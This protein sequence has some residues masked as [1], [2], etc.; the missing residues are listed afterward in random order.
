MTVAAA[1]VDGAPEAKNSF[2]YVI[3]HD[4]SNV[5]KIGKA[6]DPVFRLGTIQRMS[7]VK[8]E[9]RARFDGGYRLETALHRKFKHLRIHGEWF[10]FGG[11]DPL[12]EVKRAVDDIQAEWDVESYETFE[13]EFE[14][15]SRADVFLIEGRLRVM[16]D[17]NDGGWRCVGRSNT[18]G[19]RRHFSKG[20]CLN[21]FDVRHGD[22]VAAALWVIPGL[23]IV[24]GWDLDAG[25]EKI[26]ERALGQLCLRHFETPVECAEPWAIRLPSWEIFDPRRHAH[27]IRRFGR[28]AGPAVA[29][30]FKSLEG[31]VYQYVLG[32]L[33]R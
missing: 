6:D 12:A 31:E 25:D 32:N 24:D 13:A 30:G 19:E 8:L 21:D 16:P 5:V 27:L 9:E 2:V 17:R 1:A 33:R 20:R 11:L 3:G 26:R 18:T 14:A 29:P 7:P 15:R 10:D 23:G 22:D 4:G 28:G